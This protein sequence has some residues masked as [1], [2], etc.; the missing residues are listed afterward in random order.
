[1]PSIIF[2]IL[3]GLWVGVNLNEAILDSGLAPLT[4]LPHTAQ[5]IGEYIKENQKLP[6]FY[7]DIYRNLR[8]KF[9]D[10][11]QAINLEAKAWDMF[12]INGKLFGYDET[13]NVFSLN[14]KG[15]KRWIN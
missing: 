1:M 4:K 12:K 14:D 10:D 6:A 8:K 9:D 15:I 2:M 11:N 3:Y 7:L 13:N 5:L